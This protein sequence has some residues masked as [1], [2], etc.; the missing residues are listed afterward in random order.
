MYRWLLVIF[1]LH[2]PNLCQPQE[3][4]AVFN[5]KLMT[6]TEAK[7]NCTLLGPSVRG[8]L[9]S[10][11]ISSQRVQDKAW[12]GAYRG[13]TPWLSVR[14]CYAVYT[15][16][17]PWANRTQLH[18]LDPIGRCV[19]DCPNSTIY[20]LSDSECFCIPSLP[21]LVAK[22]V[23]KVC[24]GSAADFCGGPLTFGFQA[25]TNVVFYEK[26][27]LIAPQGPGDLQCIIGRQTRTGEES[28]ELVT[29][30]TY[31]SSRCDSLLGAFV[32][33]SISG[34]ILYT[35]TTR[36]NWT[37]AVLSCS[38]YSYRI[39]D[40]Y[41]FRGVLSAARNLLFWV[42][43]FRREFTKIDTVIPYNS[44]I[45]TLCTAA[46]VTQNGTLQLYN[47][48]C[49][50]QLPSWCETAPP[51]TESNTRGPRI[52][53]R[54]IPPESTNL[55][56]ILLPLLMFVII[57]LVVS[58]TIFL[59]RLIVDVTRPNDQNLRK[60]LSIKS[61][62]KNLEFYLTQCFNDLQNIKSILKY[63]I[64]SKIS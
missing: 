14:G 44:H 56:K 60:Y 13:H 32:C 46:S 4:A 33:R 15:S 3:I 37:E 58:V 39:A 11:Q 64:R 10:A 52:V 55:V 40:T 59:L 6:W 22:C 42:G 53:I 2:Y 30:Y 9:Q 38:S 29:S 18:G 28:D 20:G 1:S 36:V 21:Y 34:E 16:D 51:T 35:V 62:P 7:S 19:E 63:K 8:A 61:D 45:T 47:E 12:I 41:T 57:A 54:P 48:D 5:N 25:T 26:N 24:N 27:N 50:Q 49:G 31:E 23:A 43:I 17:L